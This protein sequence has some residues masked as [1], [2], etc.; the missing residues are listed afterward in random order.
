MM[1]FFLFLRSLDSLLY[2]V[3]SWLV[4]YPITLWWTLRHPTTMMDYADAQLADDVVTPYDDTLSPPIFLLLTVLLAHGIELALV[5]ESQL[6]ART[7]GLAGL[8]S[9]DTSLIVLRLLAF[10]T[11]PVIIATYLVRRRK[12][13]LDRNTLEEPFYAQCYATAPFAL[14]F[15]LAASMSQMHQQW[16]SLA[17]AL[18]LLSATIVWLWIQTLWMA[19]RLKVGKISGFVHALIAYG[20]CLL[21]LLVLTWLMGGSAL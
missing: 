4:F 10:A 16:A 15:S 1:N 5:G 11:F 3:M 9:D 7:Q 18:L 8:V 17:A 21:V 20:Q 13:A 12:L 6:V 14:A 2:E 19:T